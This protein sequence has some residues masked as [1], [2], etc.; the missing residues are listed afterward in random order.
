MNET[1]V[2]GL[3]R[4]L[5][6][7]QRGKLK[8]NEKVIEDLLELSNTIG[9]DYQSM[10]DQDLVHKGMLNKGQFEEDLSKTKIIVDD[11]ITVLEKNGV[12]ANL[13][14]QVKYDYDILNDCSKELKIETCLRCGKKKP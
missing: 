14:K 11:L 3:R 12:D 4:K 10:L 5:Q 1:E 7:I 6:L 2:N 8:L 13:I 9:V